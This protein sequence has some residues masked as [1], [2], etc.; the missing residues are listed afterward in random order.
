LVRPHTVHQWYNQLCSNGCGRNVYQIFGIVF[1]L[2]GSYLSY[3]V[4]LV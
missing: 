2:L 3:V 1:L 4:Y